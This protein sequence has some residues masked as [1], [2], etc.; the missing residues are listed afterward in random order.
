[1]LEKHSQ[2]L[3]LNDELF[4]WFQKAL[5][6]RLLRD[7]VFTTAQIVRGGFSGALMHNTIPTVLSEDVGLGAGNMAVY[8]VKQIKAYDAR[9]KAVDKELKADKK[10][11]F[12]KTGAWQDEEL[13]KIVLNT[14]LTLC[15]APKS[16]MLAM[17]Q[18]WAN[19]GLRK[20]PATTDI[21]E[22][23]WDG[24]LQVPSVIMAREADG[25][26]VGHVCAA[27][28]PNIRAQERE[29]L[30]W[31]QYAVALI[32]T[33]PKNAEAHHWSK[34]WEAV[35]SLH[36]K[37][38]PEDP[39]LLAAVEALRETFLIQ[40]RQNDKKGAPKLTFFNAVLLLITWS[41]ASWQELSEFSLPKEKLDVAL[42]SGVQ[43]TQ[44]NAP[45]KARSMG[46]PLWALDK[47]TKRGCGVDTNAPGTHKNSK[48]VTI[49]NSRLMH[50]AHSMGV[51]AEV[52]QW[53]EKEIAKSH[54]PGIVRPS[55]ITFFLEEGTKLGEGA[56]FLPD[57]YAP[58]ATAAYKAAEATEMKRVND[59]N[60]AAEAKLAEATSSSAAAA[61]AAVATASKKVEMNLSKLKS[62][63]WFTDFWQK[64]G[65]DMMVSEW[66]FVEGSTIFRTKP[67]PAKKRRAKK[68]ADAEEEDGEE[69]DDEDI[70]DIKPAAAAP[71]KSTKTRSKSKGKKASPTLP[72]SSAAMADGDD[73]DGGFGPDVDY[74]DDEKKK[75]PTKKTPA[76][77]TPAKKAA[78][79]AAVVKPPKISGPLTYTADELKGI[80]DV[81]QPLTAEKVNEIKALPLGQLVRG[82]HKKQSYIGRDF[83][84]KGP[85]QMLKTAEGDVRR[86][87]TTMIRYA[88]LKELG[89][90]VPE[91]VLH[92]EA[93]QPHLI[94]LRQTNIATKKDDWKT[95][96][97]PPTK[98]D[99]LYRDVVDKASMGIAEVNKVEHS[100]FLSED[101]IVPVIRGLLAR[102]ALIPMVGDSHCGNFLT[103]TTADGKRE[104]YCIDFEE[105]R[106]GGKPEQA[107]S[108][109]DTESEG[110]RPSKRSKTDSKESAAD[111][112]TWYQHLM[113]NK[114]P[115]KELIKAMEA[116][117]KANSAA[118]K[119]AL[120]DVWSSLTADES[121]QWHVTEAVRLVRAAAD[122]K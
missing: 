51:E 36:K 92:A 111:A 50:A 11:A 121:G 85:Y 61:A 87:R 52:K 4:S 75:T 64:A 89:V 28:D 68:D 25:G 38:Y 13:V 8:V 34:V 19:V 80:V 88:R 71:A 32:N 83:V 23:G 55:P 86:V 116:G 104:V 115:G 9:L 27:S 95:E 101:V 74:G 54:G 39:D 33:L 17:A 96:R 84:W 63:E 114:A 73:D 58:A 118:I 93:A 53:D 107:A 106:T 90:L 70:A 21:K 56:E 10:E 81:A 35:M 5:R 41:D 77:K 60:T 48:D 59:I 3:Y 119:K 44:T 109:S 65:V 99:P 110:P 18:A 12:G 57:P 108:S 120:Y 1:M 6:R 102:Y 105:N 66:G 76:K 78:A 15:S 46:V 72:A 94:W 100:L 24:F 42:A 7:A 47:H 79:A 31:A 69:V 49:P 117:M 2:S 40:R 37:L 45:L 20:P 82:G 29:L 103:T 22:R 43:M 26:M 30:R 91:T 112:S 97:M 62:A 98:C 122:Q 67:K 14:V 16:R 113:S